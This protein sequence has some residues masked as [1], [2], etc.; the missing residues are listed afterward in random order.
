M[1]IKS[2]EFFRNMKILPKP[3]TKAF[4]DLV[5]WE[6][7]KCLGGVTVNGI[8][9]PGWLYFHVNHWHLIGDAKDK[10]GNAIRV[11]KS[12]DL[13][14]NEWIRAEALERCKLETKGYMEVGLRQGGK[15]E[16]EASEVGWTAILFENTQNVVVGGNASDLSMLTEKL[17]FG[18]DNMWEGMA[19]PRIDRD[20]KKPMVRLGYK[21]KN[22]KD[23]VWSYIIIRNAQE[24]HKTEA[25]AGTTAKSFIIDEVGK[26]P[27]GQVFEAAKPAFLSEFGW[28]TIPILVGTGGSFEKGEDA[29]R[30]FNNPEANNFL[31]FT[32][33]E[34]G[35]KTCLFMSGLYRQDC[36]EWKSLA[37]FL[38]DT[39]RIPKDHPVNELEKI[40]IRVSDKEKA[41][42]KI[43]K[44]REE[45]S[46]D[47]DKVEYLKVIMYNPLTPE[48]CFL[49]AAN[50]IYNIRICKAQ[51]NNIRAL[52]TPGTPVELYY[53]E[54]GI[55][56]HMFS[57]KLPITNFPIKDDSKDAPIM[58]YEFPIENPPF[59]LYVAG[60]DPYRQGKAEYSS[61][62][63][64]VYIYK[65]MHDIQ[66][67][68]FQD[69]FV[70]SYVARPDRKEEWEEQARLLI[71]YYNARTLCENDEMSFIE[72]MKAKG[73]AHYLER[74]P[75]WLREIVPNTT[76]AREFG[77]HRSADRIRNYLHGVL[78][79]YTEEILYREVDESGSTTREILGVS[80]VLD[81]VLLEEL[82]KFNEDN[83]NFDREVAASLAV[84]LALH[85]NPILGKVGEGNPVVD[86][87]YRTRVSNKVG[88]F[89]TSSATLFDRKPKGKNKLFL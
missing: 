59:G 40:Q 22:N 34:T 89:G 7:E 37:E 28:R 61:S 13:R 45:K 2:D 14:D 86:A 65:R 79:A 77:I 21:N 58:I 26:F 85:M 25:P 78:K 11:P 17:G 84:A 48:E 50:N 6:I 38:I 52:G 64:A 49:T 71:K 63:G 53:N 67:E 29:E 30:I 32:D 57:E 74:Q 4:E 51:Q 69:M 41:L 19:I 42:E 72:Y 73:D 60:V 27:F 20:W 24:G 3:G 54:S 82:I 35:K 5:D 66:S 1:E 18:L 44:E 31:E 47:P 62:L 15:S 55:L 36:K 43:L 8:L 39:G 88:L 68:K 76:V 56:S 75:E 12:P 80:R 9:I 10:Y 33:Q 87:L 46:K 16:F 83:D 81:P 70:A 23:T